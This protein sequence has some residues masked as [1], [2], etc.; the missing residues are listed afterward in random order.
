MATLWAESAMCR[1]TLHQMVCSQAP[2]TG[3]SD[4]AMLGVIHDRFDEGRTLLYKHRKERIVI[5]E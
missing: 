1:S 3:F 4:C 2:G 5:A